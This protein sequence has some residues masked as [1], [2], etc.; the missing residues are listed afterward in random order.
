MDVITIAWW[1]GALGIIAGI[2][3]GIFFSLSLRKMAGELKSS[4]SYLVISSLIYVVFSSLMVIYGILQVE[5]T[6]VK[7]AIIPVLFFI[8]A[9]F[10]GLG[11][12]NLVNL[13]NNLSKGK[14]KCN[15]KKK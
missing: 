5:I 11:S 4:L 1:I 2:I 6:D 10:Y 14:K 9:L 8:N 13:L 7:W 15:A 3:G 12:K